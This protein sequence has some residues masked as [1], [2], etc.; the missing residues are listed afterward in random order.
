MPGRI[1]TAVTCLAISLAYC[2]SGNAASAEDAPPATTGAASGKTVRTELEYLT[3][4]Q[5][6]DRR[7][8]AQAEASDDPVVVQ[9]APKVTAQRAVRSATPQETAPVPRQ[10]AAMPSAPKERSISSS[11]S[12]AKTDRSAST[13]RK[14][15]S[16]H[17]SSSWGLS[18]LF[19]GLREAIVSSRVQYLPLLGSAPVR[20]GAAPEF[21][22]VKIANLG[23]FEARMAAMA[24][25]KEKAAR[26]KAAR[27]AELASAAAAAESQSSA[28]KRSSPAVQ[29]EE[30]VAQAAKGDAGNS[31]QAPSVSAS[32]VG[33][34]L[35]QGNESISARSSVRTT[36]TGTASSGNVD[37]IPVNSEVVMKYFDG[38]ESGPAVKVGVPF[39]MPYQS[40]QPLIMDSRANYSQTDAGTQ[41]GASSK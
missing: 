4:R 17:K 30:S 37:Y 31:G 7:K 34:S 15:K 10:T 41:N 39:V 11:L 16:A 25:A 2:A 35:A 9:E 28:G 22:R 13:S 19:K 6:L 23:D 14:R 36:P 12:N 8:A 27:E 33:G 32:V 18:F 5:N 20:F 21:D 40:E 3:S 26:E 24:E 38:A 29:A 1:K